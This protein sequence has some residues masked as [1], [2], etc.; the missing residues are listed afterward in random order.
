MLHKNQHS[1]AKYANEEDTTTTWGE[2]LSPRRRRTPAVEVHAGIAAILVPAQAGSAEC[3]GSAPEQ[4][5][6]RRAGINHHSP[7]IR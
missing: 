2:S 3:H 5:T 1:A 4:G 7:G 6:R